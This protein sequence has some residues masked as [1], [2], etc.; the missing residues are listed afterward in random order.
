MFIGD[1]I[2]LIA[3]RHRDVPLELHSVERFEDG[4]AAVMMV[5]AGYRSQALGQ[6]VTLP[7]E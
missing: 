4:L 6:A 2:P 1:G 7:L 3:R 5:E